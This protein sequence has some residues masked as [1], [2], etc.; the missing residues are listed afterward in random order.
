VLLDCG[1][2]EEFDESLLQPLKQVIHDIDAVLITHPDIQHMGAL[3][4]A[5]GKLGLTAPIYCTVP[6]MKM[7]QMVMYDLFQYRLQFDFKIFDLDDVDAAFEG[8]T[9]LRY[10]Q[11]VDL[12]GKAEGVNIT[13]FT[14][15]HLIGGTLWQITKETETILYAVD[16]NHAKERHLNRSVLGTFKNPTLMITDSLNTRVTRPRRADRDKKLIETMMNTLQ[17]RGNVLLPC[18][19]AG[20][21]LELLLTL[22]A[23]WLK[24]RL[25]DSAENYSL[26]L[27]TNV[28]YN[29]VEFATQLIEWMSDDVMKS[30]NQQRD[31]PFDLKHLRL[32]HSRKEYDALAARGP[33]VVLASSETLACGFAQDL[34]VDF[35]TQANS[36]VV[37]TSRCAASTLAT[38]VMRAAGALDDEEEDDDDDA[39]DDGDGGVGGGVGGGGADAKTSAASANAKRETK[40]TKAKREPGPFSVTFDRYRNVK[41]HGEALTEHRR[42]LQQQQEQREHEE[43]M[44]T[45]AADGDG[46]DE[47]SEDEDVDDDDDDD[48]DVGGGGLTGAPR[49]QRKRRKRFRLEAAFPMYPE[50]EHRPQWDVYGA[51]IDL[52]HF[53]RLTSTASVPQDSG[54][55]AEEAAAAVVA[56][57]REAAAATAA[58]EEA[59][60]ADAAEAARRA[61]DPHK[62]VV[63]S[64]TIDVR[65]R[66]IYI[67]YEG[68]SDG[69]SIKTLLATVEPRKLVLVRGGAR[70]K[71]LLVDFVA[72]GSLRSTCKQVMVPLAN[73]MMDV[74][75]DTNVF[76]V[77]IRDTLAQSLS[78]LAVGD[79][80]YE[81]AYAE[82]AVSVNYDECPIP[83]L[84]P[85]AMSTAVDAPLSGHNAVY[86]GNVKFSNLKRLLN[87]AGIQADFYGGVLVCNDGIMNV[88]KVSPTQ[89]SIKGCVCEEYYRIRDILYGQFQIV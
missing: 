48:D 17:G 57:K 84:N 9:Q 4:Y 63:E 77:S 79:T 29:T 86:L 80:G 10:C 3:P 87:E 2:N 16:Y 65:C 15:G 88:R 51:S 42:Q 53:A 62:T 24:M 74:T 50:V 18:D 41:L 26:V 31:N 33:C 61:A 82:G 14:A 25:A 52:E 78:F 40:V 55:D 39:A 45:N 46:D 23:R 71:Q 47:S 27:L 83:Q 11:S 60:A 81:V 19:S 43:E 38:R 12:K 49:Q 20:R 56:A 66:I 89:I 36:C 1:W 22:H 59:A 69:R 30:F 5:V 8:V 72:N 37:F 13:P 73:Q 28:G 32:C 21:V 76:K 67:D 6:V 58:A 54:R 44:K 34:F 64:V 70:S 85:V 7:G 35:A 68:R 75:S